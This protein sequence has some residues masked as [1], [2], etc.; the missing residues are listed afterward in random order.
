MWLSA[1][2]FCRRI[3]CN[4]GDYTFYAG[5]SNELDEGLAMCFYKVREH[6]PPLQ[7]VQHGHV[8]TRPGLSWSGVLGRRRI[9]S[10]RTFIF[11]ST[12][13]GSRADK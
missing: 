1:Q 8:R 12:A 4:F 2:G 13:C 5:Q 9:R 6:L 11:S 7:H 3:I 10:R